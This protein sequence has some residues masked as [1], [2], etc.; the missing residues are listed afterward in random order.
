ML[1]ITIPAKEGWDESKQEFVYLK[2]Q[3]LRLEHSLVSLSKWETKWHK[4]YFSN[5]E[6]TNAEVIDYIKCMTLTQNVDPDVYDRLSEDNIN[7]IDKYINDPMTSI[8]FDDNG[9]SRGKIGGDTITYELIYYWMITLG[10]PVKFEK[11]HLNRLINL[12]R[13]CNIK[14]APNK[15]M[16]KSEIMRRNRALNEARRK[17][18]NSKG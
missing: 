17:Q 1:T 2:E 14:N 13:V 15:K 5:K 16:S 11:W 10:I 6:K 3:Q 8:Q 4:A 18:F 12:I 9:N 7:D